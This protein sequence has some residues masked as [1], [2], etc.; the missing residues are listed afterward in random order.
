MESSV[1]SSV[2][3]QDRN[4]S[5]VATEN[6][7]RDV[8]RP[9]YPSDLNDHQWAL[10]SPLIGPPSELG[11]PRQHSTRQIVDALNYRWQTGCVWRMLPHDF[12]PWR[13]V[14]SYFRLWQRRGILKSI[15]TEILRPYPLAG[16]GIVRHSFSPSSRT[17][18]ASTE[19][20]PGRSPA[21]PQSEHAIPS[22]DLSKPA[23][24]P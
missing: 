8:R 24:T 17:T 10:I 21:I 15:R 23:G 18:P 22:S 14:Y 9:R 16:L 19:G 11:R 3:A 20:N 4:P 1:S 7:A 6:P 12:P 2:S 5:L 13:T